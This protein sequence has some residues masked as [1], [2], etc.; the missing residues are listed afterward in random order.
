MRKRLTKRTKEQKS[1]QVPGQKRGRGRPR[2]FTFEQVAEA[3][4][5]SGGLKTRA[6]EILRKAYGEAHD[7]PLARKYYCET[8]N[9]YI[10]HYPE[11]NQVIAE[12]EEK[13]LDLAE[14]KLVKAM[15]NERRKDHMRAV[16]FF[17]TMKGKRRGYVTR[18]EIT[19]ADGAP[20]RT[21]SEEVIDLSKLS[22]DE[23]DQLERI[24][25]KAGVTELPGPTPNGHTPASHGGN[26]SYPA[27]EGST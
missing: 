8:I 14:G 18:S 9:R 4:R 7:A 19:G 27:G 10:R 12:I 26:G 22:D 6:C 25:A 15:R 2:H 11:L 21:V 17:L 5:R 16:T 23:L 24:Y 3:L 13:T 20:I 1:K